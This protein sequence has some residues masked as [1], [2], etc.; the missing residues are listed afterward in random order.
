MKI[1]AAPHGLP[2][3]ARPLV[4]TNTRAADTSQRARAHFTR[5]QSGGDGGD[6]LYAKRK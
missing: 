6:D 1:D 3:S 4:R 5:V 2:T